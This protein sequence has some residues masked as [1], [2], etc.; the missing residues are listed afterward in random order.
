MSPWDG[1]ALSL[2]A[3]PML[4]PLDSQP[5]SPKTGLHLLPHTQAFQ[6]HWNRAATHHFPKLL[7]PRAAMSSSFSSTTW[8]PVKLLVIFSPPLSDSQCTPSPGFFP[9]LFACLFLAKGFLCPYMPVLP[10]SPSLLPQ[11]LGTPTAQ[12]ADAAFC[13]WS[14]MAV[15]STYSLDCLSSNP[16][17]DIC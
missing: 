11:N 2:P 15:K 6:T 12:A 4:P 17:F 13:W 10:S 7:P 14:Q 8:W 5:A 16:S 3:L 1:P 9:C